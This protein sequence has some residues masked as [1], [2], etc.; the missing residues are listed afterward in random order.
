[1]KD[2][3]IAPFEIEQL[4]EPG[5]YQANWHDVCE[6]VRRRRLETGDYIPETGFDIRVAADLFEELHVA[7]GGDTIQVYQE[8]SAAPLIVIW[9]AW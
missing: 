4:D 5:E 6:E 9:Y 7:W 2:Y 1:M 3:S 8:H